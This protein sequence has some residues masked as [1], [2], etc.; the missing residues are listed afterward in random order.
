MTGGLLKGSTAREKSSKKFSYV[1]A[2]LMRFAG[3]FTT[4]PLLH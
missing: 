4:F 3:W 1:F 2:I